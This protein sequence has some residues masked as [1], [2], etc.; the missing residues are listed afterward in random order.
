MGSHTLYN[1]HV[2]V[3]MYVSVFE[4]NQSHVIHVPPLWSVVCDGSIVDLVVWVG[5]AMNEVEV[6]CSVS[7]P[8]TS[9]AVVVKMGGVRVSVE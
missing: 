3:C 4:S 6:E 2:H 1:V 9:L 8:L 7:V 5:L